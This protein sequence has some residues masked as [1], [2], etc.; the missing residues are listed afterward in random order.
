MIP[1]R[2]QPEGYIIDDRPWTSLHGCTLTDVIRCQGGLRMY[3]NDGRILLIMHE[4]ECC[5]SVDLIDVTGDLSDLIG[6]PVTVAEARQS[7][8]PAKGENHY[9]HDYVTATW[10]FIEL[11]TVKGSVT[12]RFYGTSNGCYSETA[13]LY[14][15]EPLPWLVEGNA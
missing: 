14:A 13:V 15:T 6:S 12:L 11:A 2:P 8:A 10:T 7:P 4:Q 5:E 1:E 3:A 9:G